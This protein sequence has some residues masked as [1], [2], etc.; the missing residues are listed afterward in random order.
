MWGSNDNTYSKADERNEYDY[1]QSF[2]QFTNEI[3]KK[4]IEVKKS[5]GRSLSAVQYI[6]LGVVL[7][8]MIYY[9]TINL[10]TKD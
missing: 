1:I 4:K 8:A 10:E 6:F 9:N 5:V 2:N 3:E 7:G